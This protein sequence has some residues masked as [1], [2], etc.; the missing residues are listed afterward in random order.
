[1]SVYEVTRF[2]RFQECSEAAYAGDNIRDSQPEP[3]V[4]RIIA[5]NTNTVIGV[6]LF[7][8]DSVRQNHEVKRFLHQPFALLIDNSFY[9][10]NVGQ[11]SMC[12]DA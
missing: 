8:A 11:K 5:F 3:Y 12:H 9:S 2:H 4:K 10:T 1:M 7:C 6:V